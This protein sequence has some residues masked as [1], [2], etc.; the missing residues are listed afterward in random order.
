MSSE[1]TGNRLTPPME[2]VR[3]CLL[4]L[5]EPRNVQRAGGSVNQADIPVS[6]AQA[7]VS[8]ET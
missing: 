1:S 4:G 8:R 3:M 2:T 7:A 6:K 5:S